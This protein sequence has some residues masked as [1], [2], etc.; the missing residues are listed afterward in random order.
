MRA[1]GTLFA[2][3]GL[4]GTSLEAIARHA[5][6]TQGAIYSNFASKADLWWAISDEMS[7]V[8]PFEELLGGLES[9]ESQLDAVGRAVWQLLNEA[10]RN[11][12]LLA[13][14]FDLF[15]MRNPRERAKYTREFRA[16]L[17][18]LAEL[19][20]SPDGD[21]L[22][23]RIDVVIQGLLHTYML[24]KHAIDEAFCVDALTSLATVERAR[25]TDVSGGGGRHRRVTPPARAR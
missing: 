23:R 3:H 16:E 8:I 13:Q 22:A 9:L 6:L 7:H 10:S 14:E 20:H 11:D 2:Q 19:L 5:G 25:S 4:D 18:R 1:A 12:L 15:L 21:R 17:S 24:D